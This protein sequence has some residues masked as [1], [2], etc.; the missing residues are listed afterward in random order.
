MKY[1]VC[2][3]PEKAMEIKAAGFDYIELP[4]NKIGTMSE[5]EFEKAYALINEVGLPVPSFSLLL[6]K[7]LRLIGEESD[8]KQL[9]DYLEVAFSRMKVFGAT[10]VSF[11][12]G[13]SRF[14]PEGMD[15]REAYRELV[16][17]TKC[18][19]DKAKEYGVT[20][21]IEPLNKAETNLINYLTEGTALAALTGASVL[22]DS[23][24]MRKEGEGVEI[25][26][27]CQ[28]I[29]HAHIATLEGRGYPLEETEEVREFLQALK[30]IGYD[31][32]LSI[33]GKTSDFE[34]DGP[35]ALAN[36]KKIY[37]EV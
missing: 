36:L 6:P 24:H 12:S 14:V 30:S 15:Y 9:E 2:A 10:V 11:G 16:T 32:C 7:N 13:K 27:L 19:V 35:I 3:G 26:K 4:L 33:E 29:V 28:P 22:C 23:F 18:I 31:K 8:Q 1:G 5:D 25:I 34:K 37:A 20:I 21:A 17:K